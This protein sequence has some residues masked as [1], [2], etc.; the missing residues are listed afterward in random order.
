MGSKGPFVDTHRELQTGHVYVC[1]VCAKTIARIFGFADGKK[2]DELEG[3]AK[4]VSERDREIASLTEQLNDQ[5]TIVTEFTAKDREQAQELESLH[6]RV[7][8]LEGRLR[9][10]AEVS[11]S[12]VG[13][14]DAA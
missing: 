4:A 5:V 14:G 2:L 13:G 10:E 1:Q 8:Q 11:L 9:E 6:A 3:A 12:L 7:S